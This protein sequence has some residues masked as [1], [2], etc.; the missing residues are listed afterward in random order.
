M[1]GLPGSGKSSLLNCILKFL[2]KIDNEIIPTDYYENTN[3]LLFINPTTEDD[4]II[5][6]EKGKVKENNLGNS[7]GELK[8]ILEDLETKN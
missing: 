7:Y 4:C 6:K 1:C 2:L 8:K 3:S 5:L